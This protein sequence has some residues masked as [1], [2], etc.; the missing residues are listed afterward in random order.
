MYRRLRD[1][2]SLESVGV[3][4]NLLRFSRRCTC[5]VQRTDTLSVQ[6]H[7]VGERLANG[8]FHNTTIK[9]KNYLLISSNS[10]LF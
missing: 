1:L 9:K 3:T 8:E 10:A 6:I 7:V 5:S 4:S 2:P